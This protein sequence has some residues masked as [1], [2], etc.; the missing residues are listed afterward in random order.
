[1]SRA[2]RLVVTQS[3]CG[4]LAMPNILQSYLKLHGVCA[5]FSK[6]ILSYGH[7]EV[8]NSAEANST[9]RLDADAKVVLA[10]ALAV[11]TLYKTGSQD[12]W[13]KVRKMSDQKLT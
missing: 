12:S 4:R 8:K 3:K 6:I 9:F 10:K 2:L 1:M 13:S 5:A 7:V 11:Q